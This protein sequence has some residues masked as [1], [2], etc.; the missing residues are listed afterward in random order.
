MALWGEKNFKSSL[1][2]S[3]KSVK[4]GLLCFSGPVFQ[5]KNA[6]AYDRKH[7]DLCLCCVSIQ[8]AS[9][10]LSHRLHFPSSETVSEVDG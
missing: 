10:K 7:H 4:L 8:T 2:N 9:L 5:V 1:K 3:L 6:A